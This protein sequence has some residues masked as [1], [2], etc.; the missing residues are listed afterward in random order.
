MT[1]VAIHKNI[2]SSLGIPADGAVCTNVDKF[3]GVVVVV[4]IFAVVVGQLGLKVE[5][6]VAEP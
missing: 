4:Q 6:T 1:D 5:A 3:V 2:W